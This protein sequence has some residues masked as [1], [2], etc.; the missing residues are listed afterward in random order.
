[1]AGHRDQHACQHTGMH[2]MGFA[3]PVKQDVSKLWMAGFSSRP[4]ATRSSM[5]WYSRPSAP[6]TWQTRE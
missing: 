1:M 6:S 4:T 3:A 2:N 5:L